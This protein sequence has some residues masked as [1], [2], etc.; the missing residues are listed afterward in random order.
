MRI[1]VSLSLAALLLTGCGEAIFGKVQ[2]R[3]FEAAH[4]YTYTTCVW[5][6]NGKSSS[7]IPVQNVGHVDDRWSLKVCRPLHRW[8]RSDCTWTDVSQATFYKKDVGSN[9]D[10]REDK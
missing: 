5:I 4:Y 10:S 1:L 2:E 7:C 3:D 6:Y 8:W 9:Y